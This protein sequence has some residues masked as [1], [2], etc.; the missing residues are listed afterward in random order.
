MFKK[1]VIFLAMSPSAL[2]QPPLDE[3]VKMVPALKELTLQQENK[4]WQMKCM[5]IGIEFEP[6]L[7][8]L[9]QG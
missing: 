5:A 1:T 9:W 3:D 8:N 4:K 7:A 6:F 2:I